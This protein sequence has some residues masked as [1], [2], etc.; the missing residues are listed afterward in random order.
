M[1]DAR[2]PAPELAETRAPLA[3]TGILLRFALRQDRIRIP[4]WAVAL[5]LGTVA[6]AASLE[7]LLPTEAD[8]R[9]SAEANSS[10][11]GLA[12]S[13]PIHYVTDYN[14]GSM[15][16][17]Q[18]LGF[19]A[20][21]V[22]LMSLLMVVRHTRN[23]EETGRAEL[24]RAAVVGRHAYLTSALL[25]TVL[26][27]LLVAA[28]F[29][30][31][32]GPLRADGYTWG[33]A[34]L[35]G[36]AHAAVGIFFAA[37]AAVTAQ[38]SAHARGASGMAGAVLGIA[39]VLRAVGDIDADAL[40]WM[41]PIGWAQR[42]YVYV[43]DRWWPLLIALAAAAAAAAAGYALSVR[44]DVGAGLRPPRQSRPAASGLL[45][46]PEGFALRLHRGLL[47]GFGTGML[48][49]G[50]AY[51]GVLAEV[52]DM[53]GSIEAIQEALAELGG[54]SLVDAFA[55]MVMLPISVIAAVYAALAAQRPRSEE[56]SGRAEPLLSTALSR[57]RWVSSHLV[58]VL[59][60]SVGM[61]LVAGLAFGLAGAAST[62]DN[63]LILRLTGAALVYV[64]AL[65][66]TA[67]LAVAL[68]G[69]LPRA[70]PVVWLVPVY[71]FVVGYLGQLLRFPDW[72]NN[73]SPFGHLPQVP[74]ESMNWLPVLILT[75]LAAALIAFGLAGFRRRDL[76]TK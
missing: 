38:I 50:A 25:V 4:V 21:L 3:G 48:V 64:P 72:M 13:G 26:A 52:E 44:R 76:E 27:N 41:S 30:L 22:A 75:A 60:G 39:Y 55:A 19:T 73:L 46:R 40:S 71:G 54:A 59:G 32:L 51:G 69:W 35:Y 23:E 11:A 7:G 70:A 57:T 14:Y 33:G 9:A 29:A 47:I 58:V 16:G 45:V 17:H 2:S 20:V 18:M 66:F 8:M 5:T 67:G 62:G 49:L 56:T 31:S 74:A 61:L 65:W 63:G 36:A 43:D 42:T 12:L 24:V 34:V 1:T 15:M 10:P 6:T 53:V 28:L 68:L 37:V